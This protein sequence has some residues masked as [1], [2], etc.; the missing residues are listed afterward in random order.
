MTAGIQGVRTI[1][2]GHKRP[3]GA[4]VRTHSPRFVISAVEQA[5][6]PRAL[7]AYAGEIEHL[8]RAS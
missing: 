5:T 7:A 4:P 8:G 6:T 1:V 2:A 3:I